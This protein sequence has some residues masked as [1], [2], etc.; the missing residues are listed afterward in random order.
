MTEQGCSSYRGRIGWNAHFIGAEHHA[1]VQSGSCGETIA[2][3]NEPEAHES[4]TER[5]LGTWFVMIC[6]SSDRARLTPMASFTFGSL[7]TRSSV[8]RLGVPDA[9]HAVQMRRRNRAA[10]VLATHGIHPEITV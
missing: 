8:K 6:S 10:S 3:E 1:C 7:S 5:V 4:L 9:H 2:V